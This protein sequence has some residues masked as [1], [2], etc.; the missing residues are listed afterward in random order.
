MI[1][2]LWLLT[3]TLVAALSLAEGFK[4]QDFKARLDVSL[5]PSALSCTLS[6]N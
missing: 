2:Q 4:D 1:R 5:D 3:A 6:G